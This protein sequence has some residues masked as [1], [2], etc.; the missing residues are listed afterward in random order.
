[1]ARVLYETARR[2]MFDTNKAKLARET[3]IEE[4]TIYNRRAH[5]EKTTLRE[6]AAIVKARGLT[7]D[8]QELILKDLS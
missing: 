1:M 2:L 7:P 4:R 3:G 5:P 6:Y 8:E